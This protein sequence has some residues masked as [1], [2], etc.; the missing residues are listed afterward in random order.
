MKW[1]P[2]QVGSQILDTSL[3]IHDRIGKR[4]FAAADL[5]IPFFLPKLGAEDRG[6]FLPPFMDQLKQVPGL[7]LSE[8]HEEPLVDDQKDRLCVLLQD[9]GEVP[10]VP[11]CLQVK[12]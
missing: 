3:T 11:G 10:I 7:R 1:T 6:R 4:T 9:G 12:K 5:L 8:L 2:I